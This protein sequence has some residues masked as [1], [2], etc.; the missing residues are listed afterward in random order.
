MARGVTS[1]PNRSYFS[2]PISASGRRLH[3][4]D[5]GSLHTV[6]AVRAG[7]IRPGRGRGGQIRLDLTAQAR[8]FNVRL[9]DSIGRVSKMTV[10]NT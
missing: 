1:G 10:W 7:Q 3:G 5:D 6:R 9:P 4:I 8:A 2:R